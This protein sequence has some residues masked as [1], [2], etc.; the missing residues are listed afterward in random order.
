M[1]IADVCTRELVT[2]DK[3]ATLQQAA[4][5]MRDHHVG[6][7]VVVANDAEGLHAVG[8]V[9]DRDVVVEA[10]A[11][12]LDVART[13]LERLAEGKLAVIAGSA[14]VGE[15]ID[16]MKTR[17]VRRLLVAGDAGQLC[18]IVSLDDLLDAVAHQMSQLARVARAG[19]EREASERAPLPTGQPRAVR[20]PAY[21]YV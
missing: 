19:M 13:S 5:L 15:A 11:R 1:K 20:I 10:V 2:A 6:T 16:A 12:G 14:E 8:I 21:S 3:N 4:T 9:T 7:L 17:G 18:G